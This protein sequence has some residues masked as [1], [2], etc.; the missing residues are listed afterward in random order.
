MYALFNKEKQFI[1][2]SEDM[3]EQVLQNLL[4]K[5]IP[6]SQTDFT[7][8]RW[9]G[10]YDTGHMVSIVEDGY[11]VEEI[12]LEKQ[13]FDTINK[14][15]PLPVQLIYIIKQLKLLSREGEQDH[16]FQDMADIVL[17]AVEKHDNRI[18][19]YQNRNKL[20]SKND[21]KN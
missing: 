15:Y 7:N 11:P 13:L 5:Q 8:W 21:T 18:K 16:N 3:P 2:Y 9:S 12:A 4:Y 6:D 14:N 19:Y 17:E 1:G 20:I 10:D